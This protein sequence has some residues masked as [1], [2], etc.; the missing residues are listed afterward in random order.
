MCYVYIN[1]SG[2]RFG[3]QLKTTQWH[4]EDAGMTIQHDDRIY[5][6]VYAVARKLF[7]TLGDVR[8]KEIYA[9]CQA[10]GLRIDYNRITVAVREIMA[11][12]VAR[13]EASKSGYGKWRI[14]HVERPMP[15]AGIIVGRVRELIAPLLRQ[16]GVIRP[17]SAYELCKGKVR[18]CHVVDALQV[19]MPAVGGKELSPLW[20]ELSAPATRSTSGADQEET[21]QEKI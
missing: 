18:F 2:Q 1:N 14:S 17:S 10:A 12:M 19:I 7:T 9:E 16:G 11:D 4:N 3:E 13:D 6:Q 21:N 20:W 8:T 5:Y 15:D